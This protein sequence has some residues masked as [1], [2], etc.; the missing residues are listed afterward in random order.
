MAVC[1]CC[2][3]VSRRSHLM[4]ALRMQIVASVLLIL[5]GWPAYFS[6]SAF[7]VVS[8]F[9][10]VALHIQCRSDESLLRSKFCGC[11]NPLT[12]C[13]FF[14]RAELCLSFAA[15]AA[16]AVSAYT[17]ARPFVRV[18]RLLAVT[19][20]SASIV[21][22]AVVAVACVKVGLELP[23]AVEGVYAAAA[24][25]A[26]RRVRYEGSAA[27]PAPSPLASAIPGGGGGTLRRSTAAA[28]D[29][30]V[31]STTAPASDLFRP[32]RAPIAEDPDAAATAGAG[33]AAENPIPARRPLNAL[34]VLPSVHRAAW[35]RGAPS[36]DDKASL[37]D[38]AVFF[39]GD[40]VELRADP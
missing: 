8:T 4:W 11:V 21:L 16:I 36:A 20:S 5:T 37:I 17:L 14:A 31:A 23:A 19:A 34:E 9:I 29:D 22:S 24:L 10:A 15:A 30:A 25:Q 38:D 40:D 6:V 39:L 12:A 1:V 13:W 27:A 3:Q 18:D 32:A 26:I 35:D 28:R 2:R 33:A 7:A